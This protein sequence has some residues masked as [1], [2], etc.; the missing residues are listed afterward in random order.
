MVIGTYKP[1]FFFIRINTEIS[2]E[3]VKNL[4]IHEQA[5]YF[6]EYVH[7]LQDITTTAGLNVL[8]NKYD[9]YRQL[10]ASLHKQGDNLKI[11]ANNPQ[12]ELEK[13]NKL[14]IRAIE[15]DM[16]I[17]DDIGDFYVID[18]F[19][20]TNEYLNKITNG[21]DAFVLRLKVQSEKGREATY[22]FG[23][24]AISEN[25]AYLLERKIFRGDKVNHFPYS[26]AERLTQQLY[27][28]LSKNPE[29]VYALCDVSLMST[30]PGWI[31]YKI[32]QRAKIDGF[33]PNSAE[34]IYYYGFSIIES[35]GFNIWEDFKRTQTAA[36]HIFRQ[37]FEREEFK[38]ALRWV[39]HIISAGYQIRRENPTIGLK[40]YRDPI[41]TG[42]WNYVVGNLGFPIVQNSKGEL[43]QSPPIQF[44]E[45]GIEFNP[46]HL[47]AIEPV[48]K[49]LLEG[50]R[51]CSLQH[52]CKQT[53]IKEFVD[54][55][56]ENE[57]WKK[58]EKNICPFGA[59][60]IH[61]GLNKKEFHF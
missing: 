24:T 46:I 16:S 51:S 22:Q 34:D 1:A 57:P 60:W 42:T 40:L 56:C 29:F 23:S 54:D 9:R 52:I 5:L 6:H 53:N 55:A 3:N 32:L 31:F 8:W 7:Y 50:K 26:S 18:A 15:G 43:F 58:I 30:F 27:P 12:L 41:Y 36:V 44:R 13:V 25:M 38:N 10:I 33:D 48:V 35:L 37:I 19:L 45:Q 59:I 17:P 14:A 4:A 28:T 20:E 47:L 39:E 61:F 21:G 49:W 2:F 11:P